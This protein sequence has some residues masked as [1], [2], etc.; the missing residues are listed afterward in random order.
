MHR[1]GRRYRWEDP[2]AQPGIMPAALMKIIRGRGVVPVA[3]SDWEAPIPEGTRDQELCRR[4]G[5]MLRVGMAAGEVLALLR[6][7]NA[8]LCRP[9]LGDAQ[10]RKIVASIAAR[11]ATR[12]RQR[13]AP[14]FTV[15]RQR[16]ML[17]RYGEDEGRWTVAEW[18][19]DSS[20]GL[21]VAPP[22]NFKTWLL[23]ALAFSVA[24]GRPF[25]GRWPVIGR[26]P[27]LVI[28][29]EDPWWMLQSRLG[30]MFEQVPPAEEGQGPERLYT[31]DC[32]FCRAFDALP[33]YW[34]TDRQLNFANRDLVLELEH[35]VDE[36]RPRLVIVDPLYT[37]ADTKD[38]MA[39]GAQ[40]M[41]ALKQ[42]RD[43]YRCSF[44]IAHHTTVAG[45]ASED[46][47]TI[48]GSQFLNAWLEFGWQMPKGDDKGNIMVRHFKNA[49]SPKRIRLRFRITDWSFGV[50]VEDAPGS[51]AERLEEVLLAGGSATSLRAL[52]K[53]AGCSAP[54]ALKA[55]RK[56]GL[57]KG[58]GGR[59]REKEKANE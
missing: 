4:A 52:A 33:I 39:E 35:K 53:L 45:S 11:E 44:I 46:R 28:Q 17:R 49:E 54:A 19:P 37:A 12:N 56:L 15:L 50:D 30:R 27:V 22:G 57:E 10:V 48:W 29:Q 31:L 8:T 43:A 55:L 26:G 20:C 32:R 24:T 36:L 58:P 9:P 3:A 16:E 34:Y 13:G 18:L 47:S 5:R 23:T 42:I 1:S 59:Y 38:Y 14:T 25:L 7:V 40:K 6:A 41:S 21:L 51:V 2:Q